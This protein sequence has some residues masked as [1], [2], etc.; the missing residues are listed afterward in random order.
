AP[1]PRLL[2]SPTRRSSDLDAGETVLA[3]LAL[4]HSLEHSE[5]DYAGANDCY[6]EALSLA[7]RIGDVPAQI[8]LQ[9]ALAQ[10]AFY[11]CDWEEVKIGRA[12]CRERVRRTT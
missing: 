4:G 1:S 6:L 8:E 11:R 10:L 5:G 3:L 2:S 12:S 9:A 7:E